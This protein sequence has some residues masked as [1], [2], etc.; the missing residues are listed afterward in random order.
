L[1]AS[2]P[3]AAELLG[4][5]RG[6]ERLATQLLY[7]V[8]AGAGVIVQGG[9]AIYYYTR[10]RRLTEYLATAPRWIVDLQRAGVTI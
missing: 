10:R 5:V 1:I 2:E 3:A 6:V 4:S 9:T 8:V 7:G